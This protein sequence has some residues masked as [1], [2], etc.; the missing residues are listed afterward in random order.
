[1]A[2]INRNL[3]LNRSQ[4]VRQLIDESLDYSVFGQV[5]RAMPLD[6]TARALGVTPQALDN[7][8]TRLEV[9]TFMVP[10]KNR[11]RMVPL[12]QLAEAFAGDILEGEPEGDNAGGGALDIV[13]R[14]LTDPRF[15][16]DQVVSLV[17]K[18]ALISM[19]SAPPGAVKVGD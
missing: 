16:A 13:G 15:D 9:A 12:R 18:V 3:K 11:T 10:G 1:M 17:H 4:T 14:I 5:V 8:L 6:E 19:S 7:Q 2:N